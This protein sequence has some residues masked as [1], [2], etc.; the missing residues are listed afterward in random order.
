MSGPDAW[1]VIITIDADPT[2]METMSAHAARGLERFGDYP[3]FLGGSLHVSL[4]GTRL[5]Q[6]TR[7]RS[8]E[9]YRAC[10]D[11]PAWNELPSTTA[12]MDAL[13]RGAAVMNLKVFRN[14]RSVGPGTP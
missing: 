12:F 9:E 4:D 11:D 5:V 14:V 7:W 2:T 13:D 6:H 10:I 1:I 3:G 8:E